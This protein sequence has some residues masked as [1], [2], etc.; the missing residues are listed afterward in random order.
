[1]LFASVSLG[2]AP[3]APVAQRFE[4][5]HEGFDVLSR[6]EMEN[7]GENLYVSRKGRVQLIHRWDLNNDGYYDLVFSNTHN[8]MVG[9]IDALG[10]LQTHRG[11]QSVISPL[12]RSIALYDL[13]LQEEKSRATVLRFPAER[14]ASV[15]LHDV[16]GDGLSDLIF[17]CLGPGDTEN[18]RS[19]VYWGRPGGY[20]RDLRLE[21]DT[22]GAS[23]VAVADLN[24]DGY[25]DIVF[26]N[27]GRPVVGLESAGS[28]IY[29][30]S[31][32]RHGYTAADR[33]ATG[34]AVSCA[35]GD[36]DGDGYPDLVFAA[37][38]D[39]LAGLIVYRG[40]RR[41]PTS[42]RR[43]SFRFGGSR[44]S[45]SPTLADLGTVIVATTGSETMC[46]GLGPA[47]LIN[48][49]QAKV[50]RQRAVVADLDA[51]HQ[52][53]LVVAGGDRSAILWGKNGWSAEHATSLPTAGSARDV[54]VADLDGKDG[55][56]IVFANYSEGLYG[57]LD[58]PSYVYWSR[59]W[60]YGVEART[61]AP[62]L[63]RF[64]RR[65]RRHQPRWP[66]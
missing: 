48:K 60:G 38:E 32:E 66:A 64:G 18:H 1:M 8:S 63:R 13:W 26:A 51:D 53:D 56:E 65:S 36:L 42:D 44:R 47:G 52:T 39:E 4:V 12:Y 29:W 21:L 22:V 57:D 28:Y 10:Y 35:I 6:G 61:R 54:R 58:V 31:G 33:V 50:R 17:A 5:V 49:K 14:P 16:D 3:P 41:A 40:S 27:R 19:V 9:A 11:F 45:G 30:G 24:L 25:Q 59:P 15:L 55:P 37:S 62:D 2:Q 20:K 46:Y 43:S 7:A 34:A 23:D